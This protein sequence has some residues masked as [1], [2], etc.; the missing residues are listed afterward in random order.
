MIKMIICFMML[1]FIISCKGE[2]VM[3]EKDKMI[4]FNKIPKDTLEKLSYKKI[5]FGHQS[6]GENILNGVKMIMKENPQIKINIMETD[7]PKVF[8]KPVFAHSEIGKNKYPI[9][10]IDAFSDFMERGIGNKAD[11]AFFKFC[12]VDIN[13]STDINKVFLHYRDVMKRLERKYPKTTF[14]HI[15]VPLTV[16]QTGPKVWIKKIIGREIGGYGENIKRNQFNDLLRKE[17]GGKAPI[18][19]LAIIESTFPD[20]KMLT[21][22]QDDK[23]YYALISE[24]SDDGGHLNEKGKRLV[25][26]QFLLF[27][28]N[29]FK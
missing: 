5:Y 11:S 23:I 25:A 24:Y 3:N 10:K 21:F 29:I 6:V 2:S 26:E 17:Y 14:A 8:E 28:A 9:S 19:D 22:M 13:E 7:D 16:I 1:T 15:T 12:F 18:F 4:S 20:G 27:L